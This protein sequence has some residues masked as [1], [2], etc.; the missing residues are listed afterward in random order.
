MKREIKVG[1]K[2]VGRHGNGLFF[3]LIS[4]IELGINMNLS[5]VTMILHLFKI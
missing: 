2:V 1:D 5:D 4:I 3:T